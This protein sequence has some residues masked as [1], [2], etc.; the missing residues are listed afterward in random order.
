LKINSIALKLNYRFGGVLK[1]LKYIDNLNIDLL[2]FSIYPVNMALS[3]RLKIIIGE[4]DI[5]QKEFA[6]NINVTDSYIS[7]VLRGESGMSN[8]T[9]L[10]IKQLYG[11]SKDWILTGQGPKMVAGRGRHL[12][13]LQKKIIM[14]V[15]KMDEDELQALY[16]FIESLKKIMVRTPHHEHKTR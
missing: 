5:K 12:S 15:E 1:L 16:A 7:K 3:D 13:K 11:Y 2:H 4:C 9:A 10:L 6:K 14:D 8:S